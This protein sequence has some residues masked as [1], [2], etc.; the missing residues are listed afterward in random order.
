MIQTKEYQ[1][2]SHELCISQILSCIPLRNWVSVI[3]YTL[4]HTFAH[5]YLSTYAH[6][7]LSTY[8]FRLQVY[9]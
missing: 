2:N 9:L 7:Y 6:S 8:I 5:S 3:C 1:S 4:S